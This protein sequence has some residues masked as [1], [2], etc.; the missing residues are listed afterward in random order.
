MTT[1]QCRVCERLRHL[2]FSRERQVRLYGAQFEVVTDPFMIGSD[3]VFVDA[4]E[5]KSGERRRVRIPLMIVRM[6]AEQ[7]AAA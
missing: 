4:I 7:P 3:T 1:E 2:G 6:A 5:L